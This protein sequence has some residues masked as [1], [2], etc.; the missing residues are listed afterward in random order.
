MLSKV[1]STRRNGGLVP[2]R[3]PTGKGRKKEA[4]KTEAV[5]WKG[6][7]LLVDT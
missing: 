3:G 2:D 6:K 1:T 5:P 4:G 7:A